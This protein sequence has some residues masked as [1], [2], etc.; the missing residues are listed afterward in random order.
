[1]LPINERDFQNKTFSMFSDSEKDTL[2]IAFQDSTHQ[3]FDNRYEGKIP[4]RISHTGNTNLLVLDNRVIEIKKTDENKFD[5][6]YIG[7]EDRNFKMIERKSKWQR[8]LIYGKWINKKFQIYLDSS[9]KGKLKPPPPP[10]P[11]P[12]PDGDYIF[13]GFYEITKDSIKLFHYQNI[14]KSILEINNT[15]EYI[16]MRLGNEFGIGENWQWTVKKLS[17][18]EMIIDREITE[19]SSIKHITDTLIKKH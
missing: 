19:L 1:M 2:V 12:I 8:E 16:L 14:Y 11:F 9:L 18:N 15:T 13:P 6:T 10:T 7:L 5:C 4:W 17:S 3:I